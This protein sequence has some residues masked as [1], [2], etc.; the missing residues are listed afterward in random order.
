MDHAEVVDASGRPVDLDALDE[1]A[2]A[3]SADDAIDVIP[4]TNE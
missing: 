2:G 4:S 3:G 1:P